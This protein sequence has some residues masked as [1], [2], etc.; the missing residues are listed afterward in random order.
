MFNLI[1]TVQTLRSYTGPS[2]A[3][4]GMTPL[5]RSRLKMEFGMMAD[6]NLYVTLQID[7]MHITAAAVYNSTQDQII[8]IAENVNPSQDS[9]NRQKG[10]GS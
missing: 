2:T 10:K 9:G 7:E 8:G 5:I 1:P 3:D 6:I 4:T